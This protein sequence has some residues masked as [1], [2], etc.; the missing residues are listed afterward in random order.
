MQKVTLLLQLT[1]LH[2]EPMIILHA[3]RYSA[4]MR[5]YRM[6]GYRF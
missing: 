1:L 6:H 5:G 3:R 2:V 4:G